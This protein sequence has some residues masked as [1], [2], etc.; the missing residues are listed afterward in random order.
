M[1]SKRSKVHQ[2]HHLRVN[3]DLNEL[4]QVLSWFETFN[5]PHIPKLVWLQC[6]T[7]LAEGLTNA[8]RHA[9]KHQPLETPIDI[10]VSSSAN[11]LEIRIWDCGPPFDFNAKLEQVDDKVDF[12]SS[13]GRG[14][15]ILKSVAD[16]LSYSSTEDKR[17]CL[18]IV[19]H[20]AANEI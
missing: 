6:Q 15:Q 7:A 19:K 11:T 16:K 4:V 1:G 5:Q 18:L 14:L 2:K 8:I 9:H 3:T 12:D 20:Y 13:S 17:N 10:E